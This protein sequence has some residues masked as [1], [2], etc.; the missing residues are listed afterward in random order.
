MKHFGNKIFAM[1]ALVMI[2]SGCDLF[3][4]PAKKAVHKSSQ[5]TTASSMPTPSAPVTSPI[6]ENAGPLPAD[7]V[8]RVGSWTLTTEEFNQ[9]L[10]LLKQGLPDFNDKDPQTKATVLNELI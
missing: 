1:V 5:E 9:R 10:K 7:A 6:N 3:F 4:P 2:L 8:A